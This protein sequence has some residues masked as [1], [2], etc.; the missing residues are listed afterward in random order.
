VWELLGDNQKS[1]SFRH[2]ISKGIKI[3]LDFDGHVNKN[4]LQCKKDF[5]TAAFLELSQYLG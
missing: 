2:Q 5:E 4:L 3:I 1:G